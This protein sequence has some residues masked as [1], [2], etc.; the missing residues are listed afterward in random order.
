MD[1]F[2]NV[3]FDRFD[4]GG[5]VNVLQV[6]DRSKRS[7]QQN[8][9]QAKCCLFGLQEMVGAQVLGSSYGWSRSEFACCVKQCSQC[10]EIFF[11]TSVVWWYMG[12]NLLCCLAEDPAGKAGYEFVFF[13][14]GGL[15]MLN[16]WQ[17]DAWYKVLAYWAVSELRFW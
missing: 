10:P 2:F 9:A 14:M 17:A 16:A 6:C 7:L 15:K 8:F 4:K 3:G 5:R 11:I 1:K 12:A 13:G